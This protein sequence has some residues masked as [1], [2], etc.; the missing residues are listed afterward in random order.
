MGKTKNTPRII[1]FTGAAGAGKTTAARQLSETH[2]FG[3]GV[4][5]PEMFMSGAHMRKAIVLSLAT[6]LKDICSGLFLRAPKAAFY[7]S[8]ED[9]EAPLEDYPGWTGRR[10]LQHVGTEGIRAVD[11][12]VWVRLLMSQIS[13]L[14]DE[15]GLV[16]IDD[17]RFVNEA[18]ALCEVAEIYRVERPG[19]DAMTHASELEHMHIPVTGVLNNTGTLKEFADLV[20]AELRWKG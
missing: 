2:R 7:G 13:L 6:P 8:K 14:S 18:R 10:I 17:V 12:D 1:A 3:A 15:Y 4:I 19:L 9:K 20:D 16:L 11:P 5:S